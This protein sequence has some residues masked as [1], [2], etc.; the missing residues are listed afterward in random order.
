MTTTVRCWM[1]FSVAQDV[2]EKNTLNFRHGNCTVQQ[3][4]I[5]SLT[6]CFIL[7][8]QVSR[9]EIS[10]D[11]VYIYKYIDIKSFITLGPFVSPRTV[12]KSG[13][14]RLPVPALKFS[15]RLAYA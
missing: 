8:K 14:V 7:Y 13:L 3:P 9:Y 5:I 4:C 6:E 10:I 2:K 11:T 12:L 1:D 15:Y